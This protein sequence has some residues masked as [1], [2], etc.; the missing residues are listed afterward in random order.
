MAE[1]SHWHRVCGTV[2][3]RVFEETIEVSKGV[4][5]FFYRAW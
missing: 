5:D 4:V 3:G 2:E 1:Y